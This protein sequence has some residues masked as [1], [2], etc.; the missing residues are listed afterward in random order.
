MRFA[1]KPSS[2]ID[3]D[4]CSD[5]NS[6]VDACI[7]RMQRPTFASMELALASVAPVSDVE[8]VSALKSDAWTRMAAASE[9]DDVS[10]TV[11]S[12]EIESMGWGESWEC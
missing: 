11:D 4:I 5:I 2:V 1:M 6:A 10:L 8:V 3:L 9:N 7:A 12:N